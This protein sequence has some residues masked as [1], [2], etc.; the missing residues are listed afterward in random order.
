V[1][2]DEL[3]RSYDEAPY[4]GRPYPFAH[5]DA[6]ATAAFLGG[7]TPAPVENCRVL[8]LGCGTG[9]NLLPMALTLPRSRFLGLDLSPRQIAAGEAQRRALGL[10]NL[11]LRA[12]DLIEARDLGTFDYVICHGVWSWC[13]EAVQARILEIFGECLAPEGVALLSYNTLPGWHRWGVMRDALRFHT[14][15]LDDPAARVSQARQL[16]DVLA[17]AVPP[18]DATYAAEVRAGARRIAESDD[19]YLLHEYL[20]PFN[21][22][23]HFYEMVERAAAHGLVWL[24]E[25]LGRSDV[26]DL[27]D[28]VAGLLELISRNRI[29]FE[30]YL[31]F[32]R[33]TSFRRS[34][35]VRVGAPIAREPDPARL[36]RLRVEAQCRPMSPQPDVVSDG[37][38]KFVNQRGEVVT[39]LPLVKA[40]LVALAEV[41]PSSL[42]MLQLERVA[43]G[44]LASRFAEAELDGELVA[45]ATLHA[46]EM[47]L[48]RLHVSAP[49]FVPTPG[50]RPLASPL[51]RLQAHDGARVSTLRHRDVELS[52]VERQL[53]QLCDGTRDRAALAAAIAPAVL[54]HHLTSLARHALFVA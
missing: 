5:P 41:W 36:G 24:R 54:D 13:P 35:F 44:K 4:P 10:D 12:I 47:D 22:P 9:G 34:L 18:R 2:D 16:A 39:N 32:L 53:V 26:T 45:E 23:L 37:G 48:L 31:D 28:E 11:E 6:L 17:R 38:E 52:P 20:T 1:A 14:R 51:A 8:E 42:P 46:W 7:R 33:N 50:E 21:T 25:S 3:K 15:R 29:E 27:P 30:Q 43:R 19:S 49:A 40:V